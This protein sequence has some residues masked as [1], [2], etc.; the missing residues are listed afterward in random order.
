MGDSPVVLGLDFGGTKIAMAVCDV[1]G[2]TVT[3][4]L[5]ELAPGHDSGC[6]VA[7]SGAEVRAFS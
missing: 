2:D 4:Q 5:R 1:S 3:P 6:H 7:Q